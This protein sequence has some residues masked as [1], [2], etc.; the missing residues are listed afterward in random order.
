MTKCSV[1]KKYLHLMEQESYDQ[2]PCYHEV[3]RFNRERVL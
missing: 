2:M 3:F 1:I